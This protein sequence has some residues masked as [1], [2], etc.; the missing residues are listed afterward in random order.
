MLLA[1]GEGA[2]PLKIADLKKKTLPEIQKEVNQ[3]PIQFG[4]LKTMP[5]TDKDL[6]KMV[7]ALKE[8]AGKLLEINAKERPMRVFKAGVATGE[9]HIWL[10]REYLP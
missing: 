4:I 8:K 1:F 5:K 7:D 3:L 10:Y 9:D 6:K 2:S